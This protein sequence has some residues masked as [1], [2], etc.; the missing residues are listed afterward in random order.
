MSRTRCWLPGQF[1]F[2]LCAV[3]FDFEFHF[4][5][6]LIGDVRDEPH[7]LP[8]DHDVIVGGEL[9]S[10]CVQPRGRLL[11]GECGL[12]LQLHQL[13]LSL[14]SLAAGR[15]WPDLTAARARFAPIL[16]PRS[17]SNRRSARQAGCRPKS[18][19]R[20]RWTTRPPRPSNAP[21]MTPRCRRAL[22]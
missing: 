15:S 5:I 8:L 7:V 6:D 12:V 17:Y 21:P 19:Y 11:P 3:V 9:V 18:K 13:H 16:D 1:D 4:Q 20:V 22:R 10:D 2:E 14:R